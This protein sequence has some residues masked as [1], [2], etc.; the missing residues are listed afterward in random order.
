MTGYNLKL[1]IFSQN[2][3]KDSQEENHLRMNSPQFAL[4][5][6]FKLILKNA[7]H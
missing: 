5:G 1:L 3:M 7:T 4:L 6:G 2:K